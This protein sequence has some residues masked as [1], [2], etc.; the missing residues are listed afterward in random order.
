MAWPPPLGSN[1]HKEPDT[2]RQLLA[3]TVLLL[4][5]WCLAFHIFI[6]EYPEMILA[7]LPLIAL[8]PAPLSFPNILQKGVHRLSL[9]ATS[10]AQAVSASSAAR[11]FLRTFE[12]LKKECSVHLLST[13]FL[14][15]HHETSPS[16]S[17]LGA[18]SAFLPALGWAPF[19]TISAIVEVSL[20]F[21]KSS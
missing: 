1:V 8:F 18:C 16:Q 19:L 9:P 20:T 12:N 7:G 2:V 5:L 4:A 13:I 6:F 15:D 14:H 3:C 17:C 10:P 11:C 21:C